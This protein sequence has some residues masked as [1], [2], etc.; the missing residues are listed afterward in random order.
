[1]GTNTIINVGDFL[2]NAQLTYKYGA[3][4]DGYWDKLKHVI[5]S[6][7]GWHDTLKQGNQNYCDGEFI[8]TA[9]YNAQCIQVVGDVYMI[10]GNGTQLQWFRF[11]DDSHHKQLTNTFQIGNWGQDGYPSKRQVRRVAVYGS[12]VNKRTCVGFIFSHISGQDRTAEWKYQHNFGLYPTC[13]TVISMAQLVF[14]KRFLSCGG[15]EVNQ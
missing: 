4:G 9:I 13:I 3:V 15:W 12:E 5:S 2:T 14:L 8:A 11:E 10:H 7:T 1:M 6:N